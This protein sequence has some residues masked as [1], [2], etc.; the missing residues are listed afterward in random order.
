MKQLR[1]FSAQS[2]SVLLFSCLILGQPLFGA[3]TTIELALPDTFAAPNRTINLPIL[4]IGVSDY[5]IISALIEVQFDSSCL[6]FIDLNSIGTITENWQMAA[7]NRSANRIY[8]AL[9]GSLPLADDGTLVFLKFRVNPRAQENDTCNL[10]FGEVMLNEGNPSSIN[11]DGRFRVKGFQLAGTVK[12]QGTGLPILNTKLV[13]AGQQ[14]ATYLTD[15]NANFNCYGLH[16]GNYTLTPQK[17]GDQG[18]AITPFD[19]ALIL[20]HLVGISNLTPYQCIAADVSGD[21][22]IS[23]YDA[24]LIM[25]YAVQLESKFPTMADSLDCWE[26]VPASFS[27]NDTNW[28]FHP[29]SLLYQPLQ[30]DQFNQDFI[31]IVYGDVSQNWSY[32]T[33][34]PLAIEK[35]DANIA[36][37]MD[38]L[39]SDRSGTM[40]IP[41][42]LKTLLPICSAEI[43]LSFDAANFKLI[44]AAAGELAQG[45]MVSYHQQNGRAK[46]AMAGTKA[47]SGSGELLRLSFQPTSA[48]APIG[49]DW[50]TVRY[51]W[52]NDQPVSILP[53]AHSAGQSALPKQ[54]E[55]SPNY[56]NPFNQATGFRI[57]IPEMPDN[58]VVLAIYNLA[59]QRVR[60]LLDETLEPGNYSITWDGSDEDGKAVSSGTYFGLLSANGQLLR[61]KLLLVR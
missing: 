54:L 9:A 7:L 16:Y 36:L 3:E 59:G 26:F 58:H 44:R 13:L 5:D 21:S 38:N 10:K 22:T 24:S 50:L 11:H 30:S 53:A 52:L 47:I 19:A 46:I 49:G 12:Y 61:Q 57:S 60:S 45:F 42:Q 37:V 1:H 55:L 48:N 25:R 32:P 27:V 4:I 28:A 35:F 14:S 15:T 20:Q 56:P 34:G 43:E 23:A 39:K 8:F 17:Y 33:L 18:R 2:L 41:L 6:E 40:E 29:N 51:A 31:G